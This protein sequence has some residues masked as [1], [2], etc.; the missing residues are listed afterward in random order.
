M[1]NILHCHLL[2]FIFLSIYHIFKLTFVFK[3][4][5][6]KTTVVL[7]LLLLFW[8]VIWY[9]VSG[10]AVTY[11]IIPLLLNLQVYSK[12]LLGGLLTFETV[13]LYFIKKNNTLIFDGLDYGPSSCSLFLCL[14]RLREAAG[15]EVNYWLRIILSFW[16]HLPVASFG[17]RM[18]TSERIMRPS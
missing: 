15:D 9:S 1:C 6:W 17:S 4:S 10:S 18:R 5:S 13:E 7:L 2:L 14:W 3:I 12:V 16:A 8:V 11:E